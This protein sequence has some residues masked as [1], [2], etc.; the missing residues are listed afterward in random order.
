MRVKCIL[1]TVG[2]IILGRNARL[3]SDVK[4]KYLYLYLYMY[5]AMSV[6]LVLCYN[7]TPLLSCVVHSCVVCLA[8]HVRCSTMC[9]CSVLWPLLVL[10]AYMLQVLVGTLRFSVSRELLSCFVYACRAAE[11]GCALG[12]TNTSVCFMYIAC[13]ALRFCNGIDSLQLGFLYVCFNY[14]LASNLNV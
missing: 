3:Y 10:C 1:Y 4:L 5:S 11:L 12:L 2:Y 7:M 8:L 6:L 9:M 13:S 14:A